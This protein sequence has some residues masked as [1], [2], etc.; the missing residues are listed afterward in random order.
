LP[1]LEEIRI[2]V[3]LLA[4]GLLVSTV[5][6]LVFG[7]VP[8]V[9]ASR[10]DLSR[11]LAGIG[12]GTMDSA[13]VRLRQLLVVAQMALATM[14]LVGAALLLQ[15]FLRLQR[16]PLGFDAGNVEI[17][18]MSLPR[19]TYSDAARMSGFYERLLAAIDASGQVQAAAIATSAPFAPGVR[20]GFRPFDRDRATQ[21]GADGGAAEHIV[22]AGYFRALGMPLLAGRFFD[23]GDDA[24]SA[25]V[26]VVS[27][28]FARTWW[29]DTNPL[30]QTF[31][32]SGRTYEVVGVVGDVRGNDV[33]GVRGGGADREPRA[34]AYFSA[35]QQPQ[36]TMT[37]IV[38]TNGDPAGV[39]AIVRDAVRELEPTLPL[40]QVRPLQDWIADSAAPTRFSATL[41]MVFAACALLLA[42]IGIYG[43]LA[44]SVACRTREIGVRMAIGATR[45]R[46]MT[47]VLRDGM[48]WA[49]S[50]IVLGLV[51]AFAAASLFATLLFDVSPRDPATFAGVGGAISLVAV[52][53]CAIPAIRAVRV[54]PTTAMR[55]D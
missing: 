14:L 16:V 33:Q 2:D 34:A 3:N 39:M 6:G 40:Q 9:R 54:D 11:S 23:D 36:R 20:A 21:G 32:R 52:L 22:S 45:H 41:A 28:R 13:R 29:A 31:E 42:S 15:G 46:I 1:R 30:G 25:P 7:V 18:R 43:V 55:V 44:F 5:A 49:L 38:R 50:G 26:A 27:Q 48:S 35:R 47:L 53:A 17:V 51:G 24:G 12:R 10:S 19:P 8:A 4:F 37:L